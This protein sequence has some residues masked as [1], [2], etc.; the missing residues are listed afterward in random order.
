[1][2]RIG[3]ATLFLCLTIM[4]VSPLYAASSTIDWSAVTS[5]AVDKLQSYVRV[6]TSNPPGNETPAAELLRRWLAAEGIEARLYDPMGDP[7]RQALV[8]RIPGRSQETLL[9]MSHSD[10]VP[11]V[12]EEWSHPPFAAEIADD[13][14]YGRGAL[15]TK[16]LGILQLVTML[17]VHRQGLSPRAQLLLLIEPDEEEH[18]GGVNGML[19]RYPELFRNVRMVLNEGGSG[20]TGIAASG[21][22]VFVVQTAEKGIAW[23]KLT[24]RGDSG[25][26][27]IPLRNNAVTTMARALQRIAEYETPLQPAPPI[28]RLFGELAEQE[29]F[30]TSF[31]MR[32]VD[33]PFV[34]RV[35]WGQLTQRPS[36]NALLRTTISLTGMNG[37]YKTNVIPAEVE[38]T[39]DCRIN[40]GDSAEAL[41]TALE[42]VIDDPRVSLD[43][44]QSTAP[45]ESPIDE[46]LIAAVRAAVIRHVPNGLVAPVM[47][48]GVTDSAPFRRRG[49]PAYGFNPVV[50]TEDELASIHGIDERLHV[51]ELRRALQVYY[52]VVAQLAGADASD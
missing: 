38:A 14:L 8:A 25:H 3:V 42:H 35:F 46:H 4:A 22:V 37:G 6:D 26:G 21:Q 19:Q 36:L 17:L 52:E 7:K 44:V 27:A 51:D 5:E 10:V 40:L 2:R 43:L 29:P 45:N 18:G 39:L 13:T 11:A 23:I 50:I 47:S 9:L 48:S 49:V 16:E 28:V 41:K 15:D 30:P 20:V 12:A 24:A 1:M 32:H 33:N 31:V 34:Q